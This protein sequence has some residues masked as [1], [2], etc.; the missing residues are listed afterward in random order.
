MAVNENFIHY[1]AGLIDGEGCF[2]VSFN[3]NKHPSPAVRLK[4]AS[5]DIRLMNFLLST[6]KVGNFYPYNLKNPEKSRSRREAYGYYVQKIEDLERLVELLDGKLV[7]K[8]E[9]LEIIKKI[10]SIIKSKRSERG[11][12]GKSFTSSEI[13]EIL[14]LKERL[15]YEKGKTRVNWKERLEL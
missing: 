14:E 1:L 7:I 5:S 12:R 9:N 8:Q 11:R 15:K 4:I 10:I 13:A 6:L 3:N 2:Y